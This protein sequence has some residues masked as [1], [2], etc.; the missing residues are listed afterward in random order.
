MRR[1][2]M[3]GHPAVTR[4]TLVRPQPSQLVPRS[5]NGRIFGSEPKDAWF[6]SRPRS[7]GHTDED[8]ASKRFPTPR[9]KVRFLPSVL[10]PRSSS[11]PGC[12][13]L[14]PV[15][16]VR[17]PLGA[18]SMRP[19]CQ[20]RRHTALPAPQTGFESRRSLFG[21]LPMVGNVAC[22]HRGGVRFPG[23]PFRCRLSDAPGARPGCLP[24]EGGFDSRRERWKLFSP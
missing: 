10:T 11:R 18:C 4:T 24:G 23:A 6:E 5:S 7:S 3:A 15:T 9:E 19:W 8:M 16:R 12:R 14:T 22:N 17:A 21:W 20:C 2:S 1:R 13:S